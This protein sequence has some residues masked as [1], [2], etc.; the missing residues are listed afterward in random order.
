MDL[1]VVC[2]W[3]FRCI[4]EPTGPDTLQH[5]Q[6]E[7][8]ILVFPCKALVSSQSNFSISCGKERWNG[9]QICGRGKNSGL[10]ESQSY[11]LITKSCFLSSTYTADLSDSFI[12]ERVRWLWN[13][14]CFPC[15]GF[16]PYF[17]AWLQKQVRPSNAVW[18]FISKYLFRHGKDQQPWNNQASHLIMQQTGKLFVLVC[19][20]FHSSEGC[21]PPGNSSNWT[22]GSVFWQVKTAQKTH[23]WNYILV[24][25]SKVNWNLGIAAHLGNYCTIA[26]MGYENIAW[27]FLVDNRWSYT[28]W[29]GLIFSRTRFLYW[30]G[31]HRSS[32]ET[33]TRIKN[34]LY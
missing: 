18:T 15:F 1:A 24:A 16:F 2:G 31:S 12:L 29:H 5:H 13:S 11:A 10:L 14:L 25:S 6:A 34:I 26:F 8:T 21:F 19:C 4:A 23:L 9:K 27:A 22:N 30:Q 7:K 17:R 3:K 20:G 32:S 33:L 28:Q